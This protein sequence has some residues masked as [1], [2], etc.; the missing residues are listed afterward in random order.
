MRRWLWKLLPGLC[1]VLLAGTALAG[2][3]VVSLEGEV[4]NPQAGTPFE[5]GFNIYSAHD[6]SPQAGFHPIVTATNAATGETITA[7]ARAEGEAGHYTVALSL[8]SAGTWQWQI[9]PEADY[10]ADLV[11]PLTPIIVAAPAAA[12][13]PSFVGVPR[14]LWGVLALLAAV[15]VAAVLT[16]RRLPPV[17]A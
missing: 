1:L 14:P 7:H 13:A 2:G 17:R 11:S 16:A 8:R 6:G 12:S 9:R 4:P 15:A 10:P 5:V 3:V